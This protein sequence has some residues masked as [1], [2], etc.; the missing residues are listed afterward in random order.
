MSAAAKKR[1]STDA[2]V[3][4]GG[5]V[6]AG[7]VP[8]LAMLSN[9]MTA[10]RSVRLAGMIPLL[11]D[12]DHQSVSSIRRRVMKEPTMR[13][14]MRAAVIG[15]ATHHFG[16]EKPLQTR[17]T[18]KKLPPNSQRGGGPGRAASVHKKP[19]ES[20]VTNSPLRATSKFRFFWDIYTMGLLFYTSIAVPFE[21]AFLVTDKIDALFVFDRLVDSSFFV[22]MV[23][24]FFT[25]Y[26]DSGSNL[27]VDDLG[28]IA[29]HYFRTWFLLDFVSIMPFDILGLFLDS[30]F[31][32][33][34]IFRVLR[35]LRVVK[36]VRVFRASRIFSRWQAQ[37]NIPIAIFKLVS[38]LA[39]ILLLAHWLGCLWGGIVHFENNTD[40]DTGAVINWMTVYG[41]HDAST[42][43]QYIASLYWAVVTILTIGYGDVVGVTADE[44]V[45]AILC[46]IVGCGTYSFIIGAI[47]GVLSSLDEA[48]TDFRHQMDH[49]NMFMEKELLPR[50]MV[51]TLREYF[52]HMKD[53]MNHKYFSRVL[54]TLSPGLK[55]TLGVYTSGEWIHRVHFFQ[56]GP[57]AEHIRFV[58]AI[59]QHLSPMLFPPNESVIRNGDLTDRMYIIIKGIMAR[60]GKVIGKGNFVGEDVILGAG[61]RHYD[62]RTLTFVE[63]MVLSRTSLHEVLRGHFP[64]KKWKIRR[65]SIFLSIARKMEYYIEE[66]RFL[67]LAP[68]YNFTAA[69]ERTWFRARMFNDHDIELKTTALGLATNCAHIAAKTL[70]TLALVEPSLKRRD[71]FFTIVTCVKTSLSMLDDSQM[72]LPSQRIF[73]TAVDPLAN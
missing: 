4:P 70:A 6:R 49:L 33:L 72:D 47:C 59:T 46:M 7:S 42:S 26:W 58:T 68:D 5:P 12:H 8:K 45:V 3:A 57:T 35:I 9:Q 32:N 19:G 29:R 44:K 14:I 71:D 54:D 21:V 64:H 16:N 24:N 38:H 56:G 25:P 52:I 36:L 11:R 43:T 23:F 51:I 48:T 10:Y 55:G 18:M 69:D 1:T 39:T 17:A 65:A 13:V 37:I 62:V 63:T 30:Q 28:L 20:W 67:R 53:L 15:E 40:E 31:K 22:D 73:D 50:E 34:T 41:L 61:V 66:L 2:S 27:L 60:L